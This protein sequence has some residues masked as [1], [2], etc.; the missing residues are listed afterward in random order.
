MSE[1]NE[2]IENMT[3]HEKIERVRALWAEKYESCLRL[4]EK[5]YKLE[6][7]SNHTIDNLISMFAAGWTLEPPK[8]NC[9]T[10]ADLAKQIDE[11]HKRNKGEC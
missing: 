8:S 1:I 3:L 9:N 5:A 2:A 4:C 10:M 11:D 6:H 7:V